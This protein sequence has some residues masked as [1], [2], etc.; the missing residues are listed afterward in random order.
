MIAGN[1]ISKMFDNT[2]KKLEAEYT[3]FKLICETEFDNLTKTIESYFMNV[4]K[5]PKYTYTGN[6]IVIKLVI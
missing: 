5:D 4:T 1:F 3:V 6:G 2:S